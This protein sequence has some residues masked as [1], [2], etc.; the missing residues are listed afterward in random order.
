MSLEHYGEVWASQGDGCYRYVHEPTTP[1]GVG[2][3][4]PN[5]LS[6][7]QL[8][9]ALNVKPSTLAVIERKVM[10]KKFELRTPLQ[11]TRRHPP[12]VVGLDAYAACMDVVRAPAL[13]AFG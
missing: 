8:M 13:F 1:Y 11:H 10:L 3:P 6:S 7:Q 5:M 12:E 9:R 2:E 4:I